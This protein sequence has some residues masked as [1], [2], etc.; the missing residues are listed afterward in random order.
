M[1]V[2]TP[3]CWNGSIRQTFTTRIWWNDQTRSLSC[4]DKSA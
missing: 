4:A 2:S 1:S 3:E